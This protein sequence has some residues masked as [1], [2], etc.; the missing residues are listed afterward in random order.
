MA[1]NFDF[2]PEQMA[3]LKASFDRID[4]DHNGYL[5]FDELKQFMEISH[6]DTSFIKA[7]FKVFDGNGDNK[8]AFSEFQQYLK[9][10]YMNTKDSR[11]LFRM[12]FNAID[13]DHNGAL[14]L[15]EIVEFGDLL[16]KPITLEQAKKELAILDT[17]KNGSLEFEEI[18]K[19]F[20]I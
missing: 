3:Q 12:I 19:A 16:N 15:N 2:T 11:Y 9:A 20:S 17:D 10:C 4:S 1:N 13:H 7:I 6:L 8:L 14:E 18:C 5:D